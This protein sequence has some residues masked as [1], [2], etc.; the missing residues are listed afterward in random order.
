MSSLSASN[1]IL[2]IH[3]N[4]IIFSSG[5]G[6]LTQHS[7]ISATV[8]QV[9]NLFSQKIMKGEQ[10]HFIRF[11]NHRMIF[12]FSPARKEELV[13]IVLIPIDRSARQIL[14]TMSMILGLLEEFL[15]GNILDAQNRHLDCF[16]QILSTHEDSLYIIPRTADGILAALVLLTAFAHDMQLGIQKV[17]SNIRFINPQKPQEISNILHQAENKRILS[18]IDIPEAETRENILVFGIESP[19]RQYFSALPGE[20]IYDALGRIFGEKSNAA[21]MRSF[22]ANE[23]AQEIAQS[24][25]LFPESEDGFIRK[26][27]LLNTVLQP[28]KDI[29]VSI[30]T[31]VMQKLRE[32]SSTTRE[33]SRVKHKFPKDVPVDDLDA[34]TEHLIEEEIAE[35]KP[36]VQDLGVKNAQALSAEPDAIPSA[37]QIEPITTIPSRKV[38]K[39]TMVQLEKAKKGGHEYRF[40][41]I[42]ILLD[43]SPF[44]LNITET[45]S[46]PYDPSKMTIRVFN[47]QNR[48]FCIHILTSSD[49]LPPLKESMEDLSMRLGGETQL[50]KDHIS[51]Q[52]PVEKQSN[53]IKA[54]LWLLIVEYLTQVELNKF[55]LSKRFE[56]PREGSILIIPPKRD[57]VR[58][59]IPSKFK[60]F[61]VEEEV[62]RKIEQEALWTLGQSQDTLISKLMEPLKHGEGVV[63]IASDRN[64]EMEEIALFLLLVSETCGI[65]FS[66]W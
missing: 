40:N 49:R 12:L 59:K 62:R 42:P 4:R 11:E 64:Q 45:D 53:A 44:A 25:S 29:I 48:Q 56:I 17:V 47:N 21:K 7:K 33:T 5:S 28:G 23:D 16:H 9:L 38:T 35:V 52:G 65:G 37:I 30:S 36:I 51:I 39:E 32:L 55:P 46:L 6:A 3:Q 27:I 63:F 58:E 13:A 43:T 26:E 19:L 57:F 66:R 24:I 1:D 54:L 31:P 14:P 8:T 2:V 18:F 10:I 50:H 41:S 34:L 61:V 15:Q 20:R 22:I 60:T